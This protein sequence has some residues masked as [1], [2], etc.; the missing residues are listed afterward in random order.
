M[1]FLSKLII[2]MAVAMACLTSCSRN[3]SAI[4]AMVDELNS[5]TFRAM[6]AKTG[7]FDD[8]KAEIDGDSL[9]IT[10]LCRPWINLSGISQEQMPQLQASALSEFREKL[11][12]E[13]FRKGIE[14]LAEEHM[15]IKMVWQDVNGK[16]IDIK[17]DPAE[18]LK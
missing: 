1:K 9:V 15:A 12:D 8:S 7:L 14:A 13:N 10:F 2:C 17:V 18:V 16:S 3:S 6:E 5:P 4:Q 11:A